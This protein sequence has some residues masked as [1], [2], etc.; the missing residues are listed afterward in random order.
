MS[1]ARST[2]K[3]TRRAGYLVVLVV[4]LA[5]PTLISHPASAAIHHHLRP[6]VTENPVSLA[7][8]SESTATFTSQAK[9]YTAVTWQQK[10]P[11]GPWVE[12]A[13][14]N[15]PSLTL[16]ATYQLNGYQ[17]RAVFKNHTAASTS[18]DATLSVYAA[19][20]SWSGYATTLGPVAS[21][22]GSWTVPTVTC[23][24]S[25]TSTWEWV[26]ISSPAS[27]TIEQLGTA[28]VCANGVPSYFPWYET[29]GN[30]A[31]NN[32]YDVPIAEPVSPGDTITASISDDASSWDFTL[33]DGSAWSFTANVTLSAT[34]AFAEWIVEDPL[35]CPN[36]DTSSC[37][38]DSLAAISPVTFTNVSFLYNDQET[39]LNADNSEAMEMVMNNTPASVP[40]LLEV[41]GS[42]F[43]VT[44]PPPLP[45]IS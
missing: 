32:G 43:S 6:A 41:G 14:A 12:V 13:S 10:S 26:G 34:P 19:N 24:Q 40:G 45:P 25:P 30:P 16:T 7:L 23:N 31:L 33:S 17:Y 2:T 3:P 21:A 35:S 37:T 15:T 9:N 39:Y 4:A 38:Q 20:A 11:S 27:A 28:T 29:W 18:A 42:V 44:E 8:P 36:S 22:I 5:S 1:G